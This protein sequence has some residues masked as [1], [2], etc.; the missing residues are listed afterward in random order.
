[1]AYT[2]SID[3]TWD[4]MHTGD[5]LEVTEEFQKAFLWEG[6]VPEL[7]HRVWIDQLYDRHAARSED[8]C[9]VAFFENDTLPMHTRKEASISHEMAMDMRRAYLRTEFDRIT[10]L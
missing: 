1:M 6:G 5:N 7:G 10:A 4:D 8:Y 3:F 9:R 2:Y